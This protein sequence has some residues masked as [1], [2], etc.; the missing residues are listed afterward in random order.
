MANI[1][2]K[3]AIRT[4]FTF[5]S[6][7][8]AQKQAAFTT[9]KYMKR[10]QGVSIEMGRCCIEVP[11]MPGVDEDMRRWSFFMILEHNAIVNKSITAMVYQLA[12]GEPLH[13]AAAIDAKKD[14]LPSATAGG[15]Q[16]DAFER[17]V[18][19]HFEAIRSLER[20]RGTKTSV[21]PV[22][23]KFDAHKWNCMFSFHLKLHYPQAVKVLRGAA[24]EGSG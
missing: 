16:V 7:Q 20:L 3:T 22:F 14:V 6:R 19:E 1:F 2:L 8:R 12:K 13:G 9:E 21:H 24:A 23:G 15:E 5:T 10:A 17:S 11:P 18:R 4:L